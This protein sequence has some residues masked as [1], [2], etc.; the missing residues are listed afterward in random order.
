MS[1]TPQPSV[2]QL[3]VAFGEAALNLVP[4]GVA[5]AQLVP[6]AQQ[7]YDMVVNKSATAQDFTVDD[8]QAIV[9][10]NDAKLRK[11]EADLAAQGKSPT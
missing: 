3:V 2:E 1:A 9:D 10:A 7:F 6:A 8:L 5:F 11:A 4:G